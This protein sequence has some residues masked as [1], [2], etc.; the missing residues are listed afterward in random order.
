MAIPSL[1]G[2]D[3]PLA[4]A[5]GSF[6]GLGIVETASFIDIVWSRGD[7]SVQSASTSMT[8]AWGIRG[9]V[10]KSG[11]DFA[12]QASTERSFKRLSALAG[13]F[14]GFEDTGLVGRNEGTVGPDTH[15]EDGAAVL[16]FSRSDIAPVGVGA[17]EDMVETPVNLNK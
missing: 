5:F 1:S 6:G 13:C 15:E 3:L 11:S 7:L 12:S 16:V 2:L 14:G 10:V 17:G 4:V 8:E 9:T